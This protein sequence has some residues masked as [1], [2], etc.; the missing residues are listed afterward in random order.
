MDQTR[1][2]D[3]EELMTDQ[4]F[5]IIPFTMIRPSDQYNIILLHYSAG[6]KERNCTLVKDPLIF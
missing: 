2:E 6:K 5:R 3:R 1:G 4:P